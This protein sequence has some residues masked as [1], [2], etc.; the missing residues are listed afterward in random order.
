MG[1]VG[2]RRAPTGAKKFFDSHCF[3]F[4]V[5]DVV[6]EGSVEDEKSL[7]IGEVAKFQFWQERREGNCQVTTSGGILDAQ[8]LEK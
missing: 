3:C 1:F 4:P 7:Q 6:G 8:L 2:G 5:E